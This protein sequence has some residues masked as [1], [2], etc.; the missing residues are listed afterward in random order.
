MLQVA[1]EKMFNGIGKGLVKN[2]TSEEDINTLIECTAEN[3]SPALKSSD[4][5]KMK[6]NFYV[7][8]FIRLSI[9][10]KT[11]ECLSLIEKCRIEFPEILFL[12]G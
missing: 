2:R 3:P 4:I 11:S 7:F 1:L 9:V 12:F 6:S 5:S 10:G 8:I